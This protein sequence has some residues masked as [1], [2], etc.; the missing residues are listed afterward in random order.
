MAGS[1][2]ASMFKRCDTII[3]LDPY[4]TKSIWSVSIETRSTLFNLNTLNYLL[5]IRE[6][7]KSLSYKVIL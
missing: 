2:L 4:A 3:S 1:V 7:E 6:S 5:S